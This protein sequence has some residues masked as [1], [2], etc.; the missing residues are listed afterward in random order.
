M[1]VVGF[2]FSSTNPPVTEIV[3][4]ISPIVLY[5]IQ[6]FGFDR[7]VFGS[8]FPVDKASFSYLNL[9]QALKTIFSENSFS[10]EN[11]RKIFFSNAIKL[12]ALSPES[13]L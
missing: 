2:P 12:Y 5:I 9:V 6:T 10:I 3:Q 4:L 11:Q 8:N 1:P 7:I 13:M